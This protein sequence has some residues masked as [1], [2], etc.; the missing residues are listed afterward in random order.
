[1]SADL[2]GVRKGYL[3]L[4]KPTAVRALEMAVAT[5]CSM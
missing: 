5:V 2:D 4:N 1:M 3:G